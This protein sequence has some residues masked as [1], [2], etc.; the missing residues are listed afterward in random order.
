M[1]E[2]K[3]IEDGIFIDG[4]NQP[5]T[6]LFKIYD[7]MGN[8]W[9]EVNFKNGKAVSGYKYSVDGPKNTN[10]RCFLA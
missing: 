7:E 3:L 2:L 10:E 4:N 6:G 1:S 8:L 5:V 9:I